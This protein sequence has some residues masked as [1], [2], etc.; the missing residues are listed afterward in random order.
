[1]EYLSKERHDRIVAEL[2]Q[3]IDEAMYSHSLLLAAVAA[4]APAVLPKPA[5][6]TY[7]ADTAAGISNE[8]H[9]HR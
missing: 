5:Q 9:S 6:M 1:M 4:A 2:K 3:L 8:G 7:V